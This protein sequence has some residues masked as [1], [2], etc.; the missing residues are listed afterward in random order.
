LPAL[1]RQPTS[2]LAISS[3]WSAELWRTCREAA[4]AAR[5]MFSDLSSFLI[6]RK[7]EL[8]SVV[9]ETNRRALWL[10][11]VPESSQLA[12]TQAAESLCR[13]PA[14]R[15]TLLRRPTPYPARYFE[16]VLTPVLDTGFVPR[17]CPHQ[18]SVE[19]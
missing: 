2:D 14:A 1:L 11:V 15:T 19:M 16:Q 6:L 4:S 3:L 17:F 18:E 7:Y 13:C 5:K 12:V 8:V 9:A 10:I